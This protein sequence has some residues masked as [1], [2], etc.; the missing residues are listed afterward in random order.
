MVDDP[1]RDAV[2]RAVQACHELL[3]WLIPQLDLFPRARRFTLGERLE[4]GLLRVL[5]ALVE[6]AYSREK[7]AALTI[8]NRTLEIE[9]HLWRLAHELRVI[10]LKRYEQGARLMDDLGRQIGGWLR[11]RAEGA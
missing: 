8:A 10:P 11:S 7:R 4:T 5:E 6:A 9:R 2:P 1:P 3:V